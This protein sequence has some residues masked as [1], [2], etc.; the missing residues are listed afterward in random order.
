MTGPALGGGTFGSGGI[1]GGL[2]AELVLL[3]ALGSA[4]WADDAGARV[5]AFVAGADDA[6]ARVGAFV[7]GAV[8]TSAD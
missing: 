7:A 4:G 3:T 2:A 8:V 5:G 1:V 6:G